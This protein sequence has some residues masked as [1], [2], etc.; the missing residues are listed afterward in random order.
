MKSDT[1]LRNDVMAELKQK[2]DWQP[3]IDTSHISVAVKNNVVTLSGQ[4]MHCNEKRAAEVTVNG[5]YGVKAVANEIVVESNGSLRHTDQDIAEAVLSLMK[6]DYDVPAA[7][8]EVNVKDGRVKL[9][10]TVD[11]LYQKVAAR[12]CVRDLMGVKAV[13]NS[14]T[15]RPAVEWIND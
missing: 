15:I 10:G 14:I 9:E 4:A 8:I 13:T 5:V 1:Q 11:W 3:K 7:A 12:R 2:R 6:W